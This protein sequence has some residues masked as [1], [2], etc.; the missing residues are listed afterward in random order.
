MSLL[1]KSLGRGI[2]HYRTSSGMSQDDLS[3]LLGVSLQTL[4]LWET[5]VS[6]PHRVSFVTKL[7]E[8]FGISELDLFCPAKDG[9]EDFLLPNVKTNDSVREKVIKEIKR[10]RLI[11]GMS[12]QELAE[13]VGVR[14]LTISRIERGETR[15]NMK[16]LPKF[17]E[18]LGVTKEELLNPDPN[19]GKPR[20]AKIHRERKEKTMT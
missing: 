12:Q 13:K 17:A 3:H 10:L 19:A 4:C 6:F 11:R 9:E 1:T 18:A 5:G 8:V 20:I 15:F 7:A 16:R 14:L 2:K